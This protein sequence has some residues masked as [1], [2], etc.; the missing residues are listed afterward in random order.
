MIEATTTYVPTSIGER[1]DEPTSVFPPVITEAPAPPSPQAKPQ[2]QPTSTT[3]WRPSS[4]EVMSVLG[5][6]LTIF[7]AI[8]VVYFAYLF[9]GTALEHGRAQHTLQTRFAH[10]MANQQAFTGGVIPVGTP[11][12][13]LD[14]PRLHLNQVVAEGTTDGITAKGPGHLRTSPLPGQAGNVVIDCRRITFGGPCRDLD[15]MKPGDVITTTS[16]QGTSKYSV[17]KVMTVKKH[18]TDA[19]SPTSDSRLTLMTSTPMLEASNRLVVVAQLETPSFNTPG[20]RVNQISSAELG[21]QGDGSNAFGLLVWPELLFLAAC[22]TAWLARRW[23]GWPT[24]LVMVPVLALLLLLVFDSF[25]MLLPST[26]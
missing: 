25:T 21:L 24:W 4:A 5:T 17:T 15:K 10:M 14:I 23:A 11:V 16:G 20:P 22:L 26:L 19:L 18:Q 12:F 8:I 1:A 6:G 13:Q 9:A 2:A 7:G 3:A